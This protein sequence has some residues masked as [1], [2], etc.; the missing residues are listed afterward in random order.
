MFQTL[1]ITLLIILLFAEPVKGTACPRQGQL[2]N[3]RWLTF[4]G[5]RQ[6]VS[7]W[8]AAAGV[9]RTTAAVTRRVVETHDPAPKR[10][11]AHGMTPARVLCTDR[12]TRFRQGQ[13]PRAANVSPQPSS[14]PGLFSGEEQQ[15]CLALRLPSFVWYHPEQLLWLPAACPLQMLEE[16]TAPSHLFLL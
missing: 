15:G 6:P 9:C 2:C 12:E 4:G 7:R 13:P 10:A 16:S 8:L 14:A 3:H 1:L 11:C 5:G